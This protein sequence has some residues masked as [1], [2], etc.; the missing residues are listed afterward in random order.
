MTPN[1]RSGIAFF[2]LSAVLLALSACNGGIAPADPDN[3]APTIEAVNEQTVIRNTLSR[4]SLTLELKIQDPDDDSFT[5][6]VDSSD[7]SVIEDSTL[8]CSPGSCS[9]TLTPSPEK[10]AEVTVELTVHDGSGGETGTSFLVK[11]VPLLV[12]TASDD[13]AGSLRQVVQDAEPGDVIGFDE[14]GAF[15]TPRTIFLTSQITLAKDLTV[16]GVGSNPFGVVIS[17]ADAPEPTR[18]FEVTASAKVVLRTLQMQNAG[19]GGMSKVE[20]GGAILT[21]AEG[22]LSLIGSF[23]QGNEA[24]SGG[25]IYNEGGTLTLD[26]TVIEGGAEM[27]VNADTGGAIYNDGGT[28]VIKNGSRLAGNVADEDGGGI[29]NDQGM[30]EFRGGTLSENAAGGRGGGIHN[31]AGMVVLDSAG[32]SENSAGFVG[33]GFSGVG[34]TATI[35]S[36][37]FTD[38]DAE[39][40]GGAVDNTSDGQ[41]TLTDTSFSGNSAGG[42]GG[43]ITNSFGGVASIEGGIISENTA[44]NCGGGI[45]SNAAELLLS[46][47]AVTGNVANVGGGLCEFGDEVTL[48]N[49]TMEGNTAAVGGGI[50]S[51]ND[52][53]IR[54]GSRIIGNT[55]GNDGGGILSVSGSFVL[56]ASTIAEN[57]AEFGGGVYN[58][59]SGSF[60]ADAQSEISD[61]L[62]TAPFPSGGGIYNLGTLELE[63]GIVTGNSPDNLF[64]ARPGDLNVVIEGL[65]GVDADVSVTGPGSFNQFVTETTLFEDVAA[66]TYIIT[67]EAVTLT[68]DPGT[69]TFVPEPN[70]RAVSVGGEET[71]TITITYE[72]SQ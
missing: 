46:G 58:D 54:N 1:L 19:V 4:R 30:L 23:F 2:F 56:E 33:G 35:S 38:N 42:D 6:M 55:A 20:K 60:A 31:S 57:T 5:V 16:E 14:N 22:N 50:Y 53:T 12:T 68:L 63:P 32:F 11:V 28:L 41:L 69:I 51:S 21:G 70:F 71:T 43:A 9:L 25:A 17:G 29:Y 10:N 48:D 15:Q 37:S 47:L 7:E 44:E 66:G 40:F 3:Q 34:G 62:A 39:S 49:V 13:G 67:A 64:D 36:S 18:L 59:L 52:V 8:N 26:G 24:T 45:F 65:T 27:K 61:N 72:L